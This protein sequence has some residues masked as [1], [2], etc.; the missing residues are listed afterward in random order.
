MPPLGPL[1]TRSSLDWFLVGGVPALFMVGVTFQFAWEF[2]KREGLNKGWKNL[3]CRDS[4]R[5]PPG[6]SLMFDRQTRL[7]PALLLSCNPA[8]RPSILPCFS[9][10]SGPPL[11][12]C[13]PS[14][15]ESYH[16]R[17][18]LYHLPAPPCSMF[19]KE[20]TA[21]DRIRLLQDALNSLPFVQR[22]ALFCNWRPHPFPRNR[23][24][25]FIRDFGNFFPLI[26]P[27][28]PTK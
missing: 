15:P 13:Y 17:Y 5:V 28:Y 26:S 24:G 14:A 11:F 1:K 20:D 21:S 10:V 4:S 9:R 2:G 27:A 12:C 16:R 23:R 8:L 18:M 19:A 3:S 6:V 25:F 22:F 7:Q